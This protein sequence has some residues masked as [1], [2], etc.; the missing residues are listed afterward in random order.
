MTLAEFEKEYKKLGTNPKTAVV[1]RLNKK[2]IKDGVDVSFL[3]PVIADHEEYYRTYFAV[4]ITLCK[5][6][7]EKFAF[8]EDNFDLLHDWWHVDG[9]TV[10]LGDCLDFDYACKKA[11]EYIK[12]DLPYVRRLGYVFFIPRLV[13]DRANTDKLL[14]L[15]KNDD[16]YHVV[17]GEAWLLSYIAM[18]DTEKA[19]E[20]IKNCHLKYNIIGKA[21]QKICDSY[22][23]SKENK[24]RFKALREARKAIK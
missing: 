5:T 7:D 19:Y 15:L 9:I 23:V 1:D 17:M 20:Y 18:Y 21:I 13:K 22:V 6:L 11:V 12:S 3:K 24:E 8:I 10:F 2:L 4:S 16:E 14:A